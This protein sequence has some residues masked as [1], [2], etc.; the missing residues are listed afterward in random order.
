[1]SNSKQRA[2]ADEFGLPFWEVVKGF[3]DDGLSVKATADV[4]EYS[5][6]AFRRLVERHGKKGWFLVGHDSIVP[7]QE[8]AERRG[9]CT[10][11]HREALKQASAVNPNYIRVEYRGYTDTLAGHARRLGLSR[12]T[13]YKRN[14]RRPGDWAYVLA[15][16]KHIVLPSRK[17]GWHQNTFRFGKNLGDTYGKL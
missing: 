10:E 14:E 1:M 16:S 15:D 3:A 5:H 11:A 4:L 8:K 6:S 2:I 7:Q 13:V 9:V 12:S 17:S